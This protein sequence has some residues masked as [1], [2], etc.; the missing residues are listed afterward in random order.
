MFKHPLTQ[1][2]VYNSLLKKERQ[3][4]HEQIGL[5]MEQ[6][7]PERLTESYETLAFHFKQGR[8][9]HKAVDYLVRSGE[10]SLKRYAVEES[11]QYY[12]EAFDLLSNKPEKS[13]E[14]NGLLIDILTKWALVFYYRGAF[15]ELTE[16]LVAHEQLARSLDDKSR[17]GMFLAWLGFS[18]CCRGNFGDSHD[19]LSS[20]LK[21]GEEI[22]DQKLIGY[23]CAWLA[24]TCL[25]LGLLKE[26]LSFGE[27]AQEISKL[28]ES[29]Q[30]LYFKSLGGIGMAYTYMGERK[31]TFCVGE[32]LVTYGHRHSNVRSQSMGLGFMSYAS[33]L[34]GDFSKAIEH[35]KEALRIAK[36]PF[37]SQMARTYLG[38]CNFAGGNMQAAE[39]AL[40]EV[41][42]FAKRFGAEIILANAQAFLGAVL[43]AKGQM[44]QGLKM[45]EEMRVASLKDKNRFA[46][47]NTEYIL[48]KVYLQV[49]QGGEERISLSTAARNIGFLIREVPFASKKAED[50]LNESIRVAKEVGI[51]SILGQAYLNLGLLHKIKGRIHK[52]RESICMA[53]QIFE[54]I[55]ADG[56]LKQARDALVTLGQS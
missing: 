55:D 39:E 52:A 9:A 29:D 8:S 10:K 28:F 24:W 53:I 38:I 1:E 27:R 20:A 48:G 56:F 14:E 22:S 16:L 26:S 30:Y 13:R 41:F 21:I 45:L 37:Y 36:D 23:S 12:K 6:S 47:A 19:Y 11:H 44:S 42:E 18:W 25:G 35:C 43:V 7:F 51:K 50:H 32:A 15:R 34:D 40:T 2:V 49:V 54:E 3:E 4:I 31:R 17:L 46:Y 5:V 33:M